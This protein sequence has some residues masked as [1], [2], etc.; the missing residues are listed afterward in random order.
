MHNC[1]C[2]YDSSTVT[3]NHTSIKD[4][5]M[6]EEGDEDNNNG[7]Q[8]AASTMSLV[9]LYLTSFWCATGEDWRAM[10]ASDTK[11]LL[12]RQGTGLSSTKGKSK[13]GVVDSRPMYKVCTM[14]HCTPHVCIGMIM[15]VMQVIL[16]AGPP[17]TGKV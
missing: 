15:Y 1:L 9:V 11:A 12:R 14:H 7:E 6:D 10:V 16:L 5:M 3:P 13:H 4:D 17:G 2:L 8:C